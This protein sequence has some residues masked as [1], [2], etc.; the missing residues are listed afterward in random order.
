MSKKDLIARLKALGAE[1][2]REVNLSG[3]NEEMALR[4]AELEEA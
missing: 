2:G 4:I 1:L 3:S